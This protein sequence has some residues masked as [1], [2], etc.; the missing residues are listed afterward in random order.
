MDN[1]RVI[2]ICGRKGSGKDTVGAVLVAEYGFVRVALADPIKQ[3]AHK[4]F[5]YDAR[6]LFGPSACREEPTPAAAAPAWWDGVHAN[7][8]TPAVDADLQRLF[9][10]PTRALAALQRLCAT[11]LAP[12]GAALT[13]RVVLQQLGTEWGRAL[14]DDVWVDD[15]LRTVALLDQGYGYNPMHGPQP[16][17]LGAPAPRPAGVVITDIRFENEVL[18]VQHYRDGG[19]VWTL[20]AEARL[21]PQDPR[22]HASEPMYERTARWA[23]A[24]LDNNGPPEALPPAVHR[25]VAAL[26]T[27]QM[28]QLDD[29]GT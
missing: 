14:Y 19:R 28:P 22:D 4:I 27:Q 25:A 15:V 29:Q 8:R 13:A 9:S 21:P 24:I 10:A 3:L 17:E 1:V 23:N 2:G 5:G 11:T 20:N 6:V 7:L 12:Y 16:V 18:A 26:Q